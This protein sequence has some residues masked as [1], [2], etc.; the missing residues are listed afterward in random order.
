MCAVAALSLFPLLLLLYVHISVSVCRCGWRCSHGCVDV[1]GCV[2]MCVDACRAELAHRTRCTPDVSV[3]RLTVVLVIL[4]V[5]RVAAVPLLSRF[6]VVLPV[7][8]CV[9]VTHVCDA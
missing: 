5:T 2:W 7:W 3:S 9:S 6:P 4:V 8:R 1:C